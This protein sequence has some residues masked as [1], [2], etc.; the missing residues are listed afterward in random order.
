MD[1][2]K[3]IRLEDI[4][5]FDIETAGEYQDSHN[6]PNPTLDH[7]WKRHKGTNKDREKWEEEKLE[8]A[9]WSKC[10]VDP[11]FGKVLCVSFAQYTDPSHTQMKTTT[12]SSHNEIE[13]LEKVAKVVEA[14]GKR[15]GVLGGHNIKIFDL[16]FL[17]WRMMANG[18]KIPKLLDVFGKKAWALKNHLDTL[19]IWQ[20]AGYTKPSLAS[21][22]YLLNIPTP[23]GDIDGSMVGR[24]YWENQR[25]DVSGFEWEDGLAR[26]SNYCQADVVANLHVFAKMYE[27]AKL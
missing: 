9:W 1:S 24:V 14:V 20:G 6:L 11:L 16:P 19:E 26:I 10:G 21:L 3:N 8:S 23:K 22:C 2:I 17:A 15:G 27:N 13:V 12:I 5:V 4:T 7:F 18:V 25:V